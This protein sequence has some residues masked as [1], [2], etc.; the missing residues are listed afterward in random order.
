M[1][2][3][4]R[5]GENANSIQN[6]RKYNFFLSFPSEIYLKGEKC[7]LA[8]VFLGA[9]LSGSISSQVG[10]SYMLWSCMEKRQ[11]KGSEEIFVLFP[12]WDEIYLVCIWIRTYLILYIQNNTWSESLFEICTSLNM[13]IKENNSYLGKVCKKGFY[14][15]KQYI[16]YLWLQ[17]EEK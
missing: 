7:K 12:V 9:I 4:A 17:K 13:P 10:W 5:L 11:G 6:N 14:L 1:K 2:I 16:H 8:W 15:W 3:W